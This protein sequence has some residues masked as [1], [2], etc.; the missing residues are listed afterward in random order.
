MD[1][2]LRAG[3][4]LSAETP[5]GPGRL[6]LTDRELEVLRLVAAGRTNRDIA[7]DLFISAKTASV[8]VSNIMAKL[9]AANRTQAAAIAQSQGL[10]GS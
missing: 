9:G 10:F 8:H 7:A 1:L 4:A 6:G 5:A 3:V 2:S